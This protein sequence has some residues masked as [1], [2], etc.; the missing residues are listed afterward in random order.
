MLYIHRLLVSKTLGKKIETLSWQLLT[1]M[2][3]KRVEEGMAKLVTTSKKDMPKCKLMSHDVH[4]C[5][6]TVIGYVHYV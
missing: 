4:V 5:M 3:L 2:M 6:L 1:L